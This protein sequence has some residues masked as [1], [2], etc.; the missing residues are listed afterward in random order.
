[1]IRFR[2]SQKFST[3]GEKCSNFSGESFKASLWWACHLTANRWIYTC[4]CFSPSRLQFSLHWFFRYSIWI[5]FFSS[6]PLF[7]VSFSPYIVLLVNVKLISFI[8]NV[9]IMNQSDHSICNTIWK[10]FQL[11]TIAAA[12]TLRGLNIEATIKNDLFSKSPL[13]F[14]S[15]CKAQTLYEHYI[16]WYFDYDIVR[17]LWSSKHGFTLDTA[18]RRRTEK[19]ESCRD[20]ST[21]QIHL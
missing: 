13:N 21:W 8:P 15:F 12:D 10:F 7:W 11:K 5:I 9:I 6:I 16:A 4:P 1:M 20:I 19:S 17:H 18:S 2:G 14:A 3:Q